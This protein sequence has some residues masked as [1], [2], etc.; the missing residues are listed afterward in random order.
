MNEMHVEKHHKKARQASKTIQAGQ[1]QWKMNIQGRIALVRRRL[2]H[3]I[4]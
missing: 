4:S 2:V 3:S 1:I